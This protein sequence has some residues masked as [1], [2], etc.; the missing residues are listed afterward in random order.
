MRGPL[1]WRD[2]GS[3]E[4]QN[5]SRQ[6]KSQ[7]SVLEFY[8]KNEKNAARR[9]AFSCS[10]LNPPAPGAGFMRNL[11]LENDLTPNL[12]HKKNYSCVAQTIKL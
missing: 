5:L 4:V 6:L 7:E 8:N 10:V 1:S 9:A 12:P 11:T 2:V 3:F